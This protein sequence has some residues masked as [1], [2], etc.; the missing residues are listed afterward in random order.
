MTILLW[1]A[2][3]SLIG[4]GFFVI[5]SILY[6]VIS[7]QGARAIGLTALQSMTIQNPMFWT[8]LVAA[9][10]LGCLVAGVRIKH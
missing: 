7:L 10:A 4:L 6:L 1:L 8:A 9:L 5:G 3:G 2:K